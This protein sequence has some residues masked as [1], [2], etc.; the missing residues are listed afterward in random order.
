MIASAVNERESEPGVEGGARS[1]NAPTSEF[2][3][4]TTDARR[5]TLPRIVF[6]VVADDHDPL[7]GCPDES[8]ALRS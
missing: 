1:M 6:A 2:A 5:F 7:G 3:F 8:T 4:Q